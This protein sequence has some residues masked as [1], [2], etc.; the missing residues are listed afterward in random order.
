MDGKL[1]KRIY[2]YTDKQSSPNKARTLYYTIFLN[3]KSLEVGKYN[4][5]TTMEMP[6]RGKSITWGYGVII[7]M[8]TNRW[9]KG[10]N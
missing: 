8:N 3:K 4:G 1:K 10:I 2:I 9:K 6:H 5:C 7:D